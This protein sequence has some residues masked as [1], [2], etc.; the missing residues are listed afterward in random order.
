M[1][2]KQRR[3]QVVLKPA[4]FRANRSGHGARGQQLQK[5]LLRVEAGNN[6]T[7][8]ADALAGLQFDAD[9]ATPP[10]QN[11]FDLDAAADLTAMLDDVRHQ[12]LRQRCGTA[13]AHLRFVLGCQQ[14]RNRVAKTF[15]P[16]IDLAQA[17]EKKQAGANRVVLEFASDKF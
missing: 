14:S 1:Q 13:D 12:S 17:V 6:E 16:E 5:G 2:S 9:G 4:G 11:S 3:D 7:S 15:E 8:R 10:S